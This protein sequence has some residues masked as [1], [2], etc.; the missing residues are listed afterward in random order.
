MPKR[1]LAVVTLLAV[2]ALGAPVAAREQQKLDFGFHGQVVHDTNLARSDAATAAL[3]DIVPEDNIFTPSV[4]FDL[5]FP[6]S[7]QAF[8]L[9]GSVGYDLHEKNDQLNSERLDLQGGLLAR[10]GGCTGKL[11][12]SYKRSQSQLQDLMIVDPENILEVIDITGEVGCSRSAGLG[13]MASAGRSWG[14]NSNAKQAF[15]D[16]EASTLGVQIGYSRPTFGS[17]V[18]FVQYQKNDYQNRSLVPGAAS[19]YEMKGVGVS[20]ERRIG[21]R[22]QGRVSVS[23]SDVDPTDSSAG[24]SSFSGFTYSGD[25]TYRPTDRLDAKLEYSRAVMP[26]TQVGRLFELRESIRLMGNYKIGSRFLASL[27]AERQELS[28]EDAA[29]TLPG[30]FLADGRTNFL[31]A[32][33]KFRQTE[34][35]SYSLDV[36]QEERTAKDP[37]FSYESTRVG[38]SADVAF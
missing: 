33:L 29:V 37:R 12:S 2:G 3:R 10:L 25:L 35:L 27:G 26:T 11:A 5:L 14:N 22:L 34:K 31:F 19:G 13:V 15:A 38:V 1:M 23:H 36:I 21:S 24:S 7:R 9:N 28:S 4:T 18:A 16:Y 8:F 32:G 30:A 17:L 20:Y 6:V